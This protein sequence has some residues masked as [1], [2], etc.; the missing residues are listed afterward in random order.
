MY[1]CIRSTAGEVLRFGRSR[2]LASP[3]QRLALVVRDQHCTFPGCDAHWQRCDTHH[4]IDYEHGGPTD[5]D[6][7]TLTCPRHH[8]HLHLNDQPPPD[9]S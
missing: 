4:R 9:T 5:I 2:R 3:L 1:A 6:N 7:L 8:R